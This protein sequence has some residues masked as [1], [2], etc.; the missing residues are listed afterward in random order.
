MFMKNTFLNDNSVAVAGAIIT[1]KFNDTNIIVAG[2]P[3]KI[4]KTNINWSRVSAEKY[5]Q[6]IA[7]LRKE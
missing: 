2:N 1:K 6:N 7:E 4:I 3:A 5:M